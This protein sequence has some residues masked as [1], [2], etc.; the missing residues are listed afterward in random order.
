MKTTKL[1]I[2]SF[3]LISVS[4]NAQE[5]DQDFLDSLPD[6]VREDLEIR[7]QTKLIKPMKPIDHIYI[8]Q[9]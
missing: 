3:I 4:S 8:H 9:N 6:D 7:N 1:L 2:L 5:L